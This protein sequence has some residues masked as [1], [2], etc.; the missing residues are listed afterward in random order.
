VDLRNAL[1][2]LLAGRLSPET[3]YP[4]AGCNIKWK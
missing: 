3:Q 4:S 1:D 2:D